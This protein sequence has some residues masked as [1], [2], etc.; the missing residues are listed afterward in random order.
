MNY[1]DGKIVLDFILII[2][3]VIGKYSGKVV[4]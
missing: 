1:T 2:V 3:Y 4:R